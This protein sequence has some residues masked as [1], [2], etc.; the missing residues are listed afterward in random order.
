[1]VSISF[2]TLL[3]LRA[4]SWKIQAQQA[5]SPFAWRFFLTE[6]WTNYAQTQVQGHLLATADCPSQGCS[7]PIYVNFTDFQAQLGKVT[8]AICFL[9]DQQIPYCKNTWVEQ[10]VGCPYSSCKIHTVKTLTASETLLSQVWNSHNFFKT[11]TGYTWVIWDPWDSRWTSQQKGAMYMTS[12]TKW[13]SSR[14]YL[15]RSLVQIQTT[16]HANIQKQETE[17]NKQL[18]TLTSS[19]PFSWLSLLREGL[20]LANATGLGNLSACFFCATLG[21]PP[22]TAFPL[23]APFNNSLTTSSQGSSPISDVPLF[24]NPEQTQ[25]LFCYSN[26]ST[27]LCNITSPPNSTLY[28]PHGSFF[29]CNRTLYKNLTVQATKSLLC[30]PVTIVP[31]LTLRTPAEYLE[32][33]YVPSFRTKRAV[34]LPLVAG[35][36]LTIS[37]IAAG[38]A[39]GALGHAL[40]TTAK[41]SQQF[42]IAMEASAESLASLQRQL[43]S[44]AQVTLQNRR[45]L[46]LL[47]AEKGG[48]CLFLK[49]DCC[50]YINESGLVETRVQQLHKLSLELQKQKFNS[51]A[52]S[53]WSSSMYSLLMPLAGP[54]LSL[55][56]LLTIG[57]CILNRIINF[58]KD[59]I[60]TVQLMVLRTQYQPIINKTI[61]T[62]I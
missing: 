52:D 48:T 32:G 34:F 30:L 47:T 15:W 6:N 43:T 4:F 3:L 7:S 40:V 55:L 37:V 53:W 8:P 42:S 1:M 13:P 20:L 51:A 31:Q 50:F 27:S 60:N 16:L 17:L 23:P 56:L 44:L 9:F 21:Q 35:V 45:A 28:A 24:L 10:S 58:V 39:G 61:E 29:W 62:D 38:L 12:G 33:D 5:S 2:V 46:D 25:V 49:E 59:R 26:A 14:L 57:P 36:L 22:L 18:S 41:L 19:C 11:A 54:L